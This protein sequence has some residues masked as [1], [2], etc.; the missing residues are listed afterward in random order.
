MLYGYGECGDA[1]Y[2]A[3]KLLEK[4]YASTVNI[5][6]DDFSTDALTIAD[7]ISSA[8]ADRVAI[9][10][11]KRRGREPGIY[12]GKIELRRIEGMEAV[13]E[14][15]PSLEGLLDI[16]A[17]IRGLNVL[18]GE[19]EVTVIECEPGVDDCSDCTEKLVKAVEE[20][21]SG[22][23]PAGGGLDEEK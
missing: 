18:L 1:A 3:Y 8:K 17:V 15:R 19:G 5:I 14:I 9:A 4:K 11:I 23:I 13:E 12:T 16:D 2:Q 6:I 21:V 10:A 22:S 7:T 20:Y